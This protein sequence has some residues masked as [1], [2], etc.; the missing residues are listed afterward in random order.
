MTDRDAG[1]TVLARQGGRG[2]GRAGWQGEVPLDAF[3]ATFRPVDRE[4]TW[5]QAI[6]DLMASDPARGTIEL[7]AA[8]LRAKG[9]FDAPVVVDADERVVVDGMHRI[10]TLV[11]A[12][13]DRVAVLDDFPASDERDCVE[14][15][16]RIRGRPGEPDPLQSGEAFGWLRSF[17]LG[18]VWVSAASWQVRGDVVTSAVYTCPHRLE[19]DLH[20]QLLS[21]CRRLGLEARILRSDL[22]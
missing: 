4:K 9:S 21:R 20:L 7:L 16:L 18:D 11:L 12:G 6:T 3:L 19:T 22:V 2:A 1:T 10:A 14:V 15:S 17:P 13:R 8:E 5:T